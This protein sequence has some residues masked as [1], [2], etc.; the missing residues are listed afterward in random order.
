MEVQII[1]FDIAPSSVRDFFIPT[2]RPEG[3]WSWFATMA[4][5]A[6]QTRE[7]L[8]IAALVGEDGICHSA[9][10]LIRAGKTLRSATSCYTTEF[11]LPIQDQKSAFL[12][13]KGLAEK[14]HELRL[15]SLHDRDG[16]TAPLIA[17]LR[18]AGF[19]VA[20]YRHFANWYEEITN[21]ATYWEKRD[22]RLRSLVERK[23]KR[24]I[25][26]KRPAFE[27]VDLRTDADR[28][29]A[30]YEAIYA[31]SW[32]EP[33]QHG[34]FMPSLMKNLGPIG[35]AQLGLVRID[36]EPA[37]AQVWLVR[38]PLAT[39]FKLAHDPKF[40]RYSPGTLLTH[41]MMEQ[42]YDHE[43]AREFDFGRGNDGYK[44]L[45]MKN[46]RFRCGAIAINP[47]TVQ[48]AWHY[49][50]EIMPT[51]LARLR[52]LREARRRAKRQTEEVVLCA[53]RPQ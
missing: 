16:F 32:K 12:L 26:E 23:G 53:S 1:P 18:S 13:G 36:G 41:W 38:S 4:Q 27:R 39:I 25:S 9:L 21:F 51:K 28:G 19:I 8:V 22:G 52:L 30:L 49:L 35:L 17:G 44:K 10:P 31:S 24:L 48:G 33:E 15:D 7:E 45:W 14:C 40:E 46:C 50:T 42:L 37:A 43:G 11:L 47:R 5:S 6:L 20:S 3:D 2:G 29:I 34:R